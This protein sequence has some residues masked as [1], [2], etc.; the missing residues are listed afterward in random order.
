MKSINAHLPSTKC[1]LLVIVGPTA[2]GKSALAM[3]LSEHLAIEI[4]AA[5]SRTIYKG[6]DIGTAKP[7][8]ADQQK[9]P[10]W[11]TDLVNPNETYSAFE[12]KN[13]ASQKINEVRGR[14]NLPVVVGGTGLYIDS[15]LFDFQL[16]IPANKKLRAQLETQSIHKL[17]TLIDEKGYKRPENFKNR[18][19]L[20]RTIETKGQAPG[21]MHQPL[22]GSYIVGINPDDKTLRGNINSR[23]VQMFDKGLLEE[24]KLLMEQYGPDVSLPGIGYNTIRDYLNGKI[25]LEAAKQLFETAQWQ[26]TRRQRTWFKRNPYI[27]WFD[28]PE[29]AYKAIK[30]LV[31]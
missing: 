20:I 22:K 21:R 24:V 25:E 31:N 19:H 11:G 15:L 26:Y 1:Q 12:F 4:I 30:T 9:V 10:H 6:M 3:R 16:R 18:R 8:K 2:S 5:D 29:L 23:T 7:S 28:S 13:Y 14:G 17:Q 27:R